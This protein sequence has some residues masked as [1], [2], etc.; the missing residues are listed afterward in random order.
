MNQIRYHSLHACN[1]N[2]AFDAA[3]AG[4]TTT[5]VK[6]HLSHYSD[7]SWFLL[8]PP[9]QQSGLFCCVSSM[10]VQLDTIGVQV[11]PL[12]FKIGFYC[13]F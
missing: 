4:K 5:F 13:K 1:I 7:F 9:T 2:F 10:N 6:R 3:A 11:H 12:D 8:T